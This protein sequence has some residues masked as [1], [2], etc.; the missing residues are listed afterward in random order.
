MPT[1]VSD[2]NGDG[3]IDG[4]DGVDVVATI[5]SDLTT[6]STDPG[7]APAGT[8]DLE[9]VV[10]HELGHG[11]GFFD[12]TGVTDDTTDRR[13]VLRLLR[14][15][16][17]SAVPAGGLRPLPRRHAGTPMLDGTAYPN[18]AGGSPELYGL[19]TGDA[20]AFSGPLAAAANPEYAGA[21]PRLFAPSPATSPA[22]AWATC[23]RPTTRWPAYDPDDALMTPAA[24]G[25]GDHPH[26]GAA[27]PGGAGGP[28]LDRRRRPRPRWCRSRRWAVL[29]PVLGL[30]V[31]GV[32]VLRRRAAALA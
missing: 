16:R 11:L 27:H 20:L 17:R 31:A 9:T 19:F 7:P 12:S 26:A 18:P 28:G 29:L 25:R 3:T 1:G 24:R 10:L 32:A 2:I 21:A 8:Y 4:D 15:R 5:N 30:A 14:D 23:A 6:W 22:R 13:R